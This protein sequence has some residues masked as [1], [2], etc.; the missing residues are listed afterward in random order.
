MY[1]RIS[2]VIRASS[3]LTHHPLFCELHH[4]FG[5]SA[6]PAIRPPIRA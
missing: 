3:A 2:A 5:L 1:V 6:R 4:I